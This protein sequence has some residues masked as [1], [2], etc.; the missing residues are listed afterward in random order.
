MHDVGADHA[1]REAGRGRIGIGQ[2]VGPVAR[3]GGDLPAKAE[4]THA[5]FI[6][7]AARGVELHERINLDD[8]VGSRIGGRSGVGNLDGHQ[9]ALGDTVD[10]RGDIC[11]ALGNT[12]DPSVA[13]DG[14]DVFV[15]A[16]PGDRSGFERQLVII[17]VIRSHLE[18]DILADVERRIQRRDLKG[19][20]RGGL[21]GQICTA[22]D[23]LGLGIYRRFPLAD[24]GDPS[25]V[26]LE[27]GDVSVLGSPQDL[28]ILDDGTCGVVGGRDELEF[29]AHDD[30]FLG[31]LD[32]D[33][34]DLSGDHFDVSRPED[35]LILDRAD[36]DLSSSEVFA[37]DHPIRID[38]G[39][40]RV[41]RLPLVERRFD[42]LT[43]GVKRL[44]FQR[45]IFTHGHRH[46]FRSDLDARDRAVW[47]I[48]S[49]G[50][51]VA[52]VTGVTAVDAR[53]G[54]FIGLL[55]ADA[56]SAHL[57]GEAVVVTFAPR[58][59]EL[60]GTSRQKQAR[61]GQAGEQHSEIPPIDS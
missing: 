54:I 9:H 61:S 50:L 24:A 31:G 22:F 48:G 8:L 52:G 37:D 60:W 41:G 34:V 51:D 19:I 28:G 21:D 42:G 36:D 26:A 44:R 46:V 35:V 20:D 16:R 14:G 1:R 40:A 25:V 23:A 4:I 59:V 18:L 49:I 17:G 30:R 3:V 32:L 15:V 55:L 58:V 53:S 43:G 13:V 7:A 47:G 10:L 38:A 39:H 6:V 2:R 56:R 29:F 5:V 45:R 57:T 33:G 12:F 27:G 11:R